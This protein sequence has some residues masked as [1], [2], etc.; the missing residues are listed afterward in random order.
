M[1]EIQKTGDTR[2]EFLG[3]AENTDVCAGVST[4][5]CTFCACLRQE[6]PDLKYV[7]ERSSGSIRYEDGKE[8]EYEGKEDYSLIEYSGT[9]RFE[10]FFDIGILSMREAFPDSFVYKG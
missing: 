5:V 8:T 1:I 10:E 6:K 3:H 4:L 7:F 2:Y 9:S